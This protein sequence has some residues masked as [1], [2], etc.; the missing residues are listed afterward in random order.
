MST[1]AADKRAGNV[2]PGATAPRVPLWARL[3]SAFPFFLWYGLASLLAWLGEYV[4][5]YR[6]KVVNQQLGRCF[7][8]LDDAAIARIRRDY[9][10][11]FADVMVETI[12]ALGMG[13]AEVRARVTMKGDEEVR[14]QIDAGRSVVISASHNGNWEWALLVLSLG[15]GCVFEV[16]YKPMRDAWADRLLLAMRSRFGARM[17]PAHRLP[18]HV[19]R[20]RGQPRAI[21]VV[22]DQD[23]P[24]G[25]AIRYTSFFGHDTAF[26]LGPEAVARTLGAPIFFTAVR[27]TKRG[28]YAVALELL[29]GHDEQ[30]DEGERIERYVRRVERQ[31]RANPPDWLW[32]YRRCITRREADATTPA[33]Q[34]I[35]AVM[36]SG[37]DLDGATVNRVVR[38]ALEGA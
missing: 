2:K 22:G 10:R 28:H 26:Y 4:V 23:P 21:V 6:R 5:P 13:A 15:L 20:H 1:A 25:S 12:K 17:I 31:I 27:R 30:L 7:P 18:R 32:S 8:D 9:Y 19:L 11:N 35:G 37:E 29:V 3:L 14:A 34:V 36:R 24:P 33:G 16:A 38:E